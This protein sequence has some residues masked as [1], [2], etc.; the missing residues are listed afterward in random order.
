MAWLPG[1]HETLAFEVSDEH[2][3]YDG[4]DPASFAS[5]SARRDSLRSAQT[6][7]TWQP[8]D[9]MA[10]DLA[11]AFERRDSNRPL[12]DYDDRVLSVTLRLIF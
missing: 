12:Y 9:R 10:I 2:H 3:D 6:S 11:Y 4:F 8:G 7:F 1:A 5:G